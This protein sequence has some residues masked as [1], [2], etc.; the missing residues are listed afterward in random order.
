LK[1]P[2]LY[3]SS[4]IIRNKGKYYKLL[5][6]IR[7]TNNWEEWIIYIITAV[8]VIS[9]ETIDLILE[10]KDQMQ[11]SKEELRSSYKFYSQDL[12]N[13]LYKHPYT[14]IEFVVKDLKVSRLTAANY[15]NKLSSD[16]IL[17]KEKIGKSNYY[18]NDKLFE[19]LL[20]RNRE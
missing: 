1:A 3:L 9:K 18:V 14:K 4:Y 10:I 20:K 6:G 2:I 7:T 16:G 15:L 12:L 11:L 17:R 19:I 13:N 8:E 5:Q